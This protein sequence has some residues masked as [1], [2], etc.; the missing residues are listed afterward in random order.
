MLTIWYL[1]FVAGD[2][3][4]TLHGYPTRKECMAVIST[5]NDKMSLR[6]IGVRKDDIKADDF[7]MKYWS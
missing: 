7:S 4:M 3:T 5:A 1:V 2:I 6:C